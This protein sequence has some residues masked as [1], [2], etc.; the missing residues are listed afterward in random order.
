MQNP[1][2]TMPQTFFSPGSLHFQ[3]NLSGAAAAEGPPLILSAPADRHP[4][5]AP[6]VF[7]FSEPI[8]VVGG[9][10]L[11][12]GPD[13][14]LF[15][16]N[17]TGNP[18]VKVDGATLSF[19]LPMRLAYATNYRIEISAD[20]IRDLDGNAVRPGSSLSFSFQS[21]LSPVA[22]H[23]SGNSSDEIVNGSDLADTVDAAG[24]EDSVYG[25]GGNDT[26]RGG[27]EVAEV[28]ST[29][30]RLYGGAGDDLVEGNDG[31]DYLEG[32]DGD[33]RLYGGSG[34]DHLRGGNGNDLVDGG[35]GNDTLYADRGDN[36]LLGGEGDDVLKS[37][38]QATGSMD[39]GAGN[40]RMEGFAGV[41]YKGGD[42]DDAIEVDLYA[43]DLS[44]AAATTISGGGGMDRIELQF[45]LQSKA[46][47]S[48][49]AGSDSFVLK[50][51][52]SGARDTA[53]VLSDFVAGAEGEQ[54]D[55]RELWIMR[56]GGNPF[57][58]GRLRLLAAGG[59]TLLQMRETA[60][61]PYV[62]LLRLTGVA[63][64][65]LTSANFTGGYDPRGSTTGLSL[66]GTNGNDT[67][68]G[69]SLDDTILGLAGNDRIEGGAGNDTIEGG[70]GNDTLFGD[71]GNNILRG[72]D[73]KD[74]LYA[75]HPGTNLLEGG[76][77]DDYLRGGEGADT[78]RG[79]DGND[80][81]F[82][83]GYGTA[84]PRTVT[85]DG[86]AGNDLLR[87]NMIM[88]EVNINL[89]GG[90]GA[91]V[92]AISATNLKLAITDFSADD[93]LDLKGVLPLALSGNAF[94]ASGY[95][96][97]VQDGADTR[98]EVDRDGAA[99]SVHG[100]APV[101]LLRNVAAATLGSAHFVGGYDPSGASGGVR[102]TGTAGND[103]LDGDAL[104]D[105]IDGGDGADR[106]QGRAG[107]DV[108][109]GGDES[110]AG[111]GD[112]ISGGL[113]KD[114]I[115]GGAG[116]DQLR[117]D[118]DDDQLYGDAG[119]DRLEG[120]DGKDLLDG[121]DGDDV[122]SDDS[123]A[124]VMRGGAGN[125]QLSNP[126]HNGYANG[127]GSLLDGGDGDDTIGA[128][129]AAVSRVVG[130][131]G[132]DRIEVY[133][134]SLRQGASMDIDAGS[135]DDR[136]I[137][138]GQNL[139]NQVLLVR[140]R[141]GAGS[142]THGTT[143]EATGF[144]LVVEDFQTGAGGDLVEIYPML[145]DRPQDNPFGA[146][147]ARLVQDGS[148]VLL[149]IDT[150][151]AANGESFATRIAF[152]N[153][154]VSAFTS[155]NFVGGLQPDGSATGQTLTGGPGKD[156]LT[157][158]PL[159]DLL[160]GGGGADILIGNEGKDQL[161]GEGDA[162]ILDGGNGDDQ[163]DGGAGA[164]ELRGGAGNDLLRGGDGDDLLRDESGD[165]Q[166][167]GG[168][169]RDQLYV[170]SGGSVSLFGEGGNDILDATAG[171]GLLDGGSGDDRI[172][173]NSGYGRD[174]ARYQV[175]GG[176][177]NDLVQLM[178][179]SVGS[180][181]NVIAAGGAGVDTY[182]LESRLPGGILTI[183]DFAAGAGGDLLNVSA[184]VSGPAGNPFAPGASLRLEQRGADTVLRVRSADGGSFDDA[185][186][187]KD[188]TLPQL[189]AANF[190]HHFNPD[191]SSTG[192]IA[193]GGA[194][195][196]RMAGG[197][198]ND[199]LDGG[200][201]NDT[202]IGAMGDDLLQGGD[203]DDLLNGDLIDIV[204]G[205]PW[206][207]PWNGDRTGHDRLEGGAG[208]DTLVSTWG[209]DVLLG[210]TGDDSLA[211]SGHPY[212]VQGRGQLAQLD[213]GEGND[214]L[215]VGIGPQTA[216]AVKLT[217]G[218]GSDTF[219]LTGQPDG[220]STVT[221]EDFR[222]GA[223][224]DV[225]DVFG[226]IRYHQASPFSAGYIRVEQRGAD[227]VVQF[228][229]DAK[230][231]FHGFSDLVTLKNVAI[232]QLTPDNMRYGYL[233]D[234]VLKPGVERRAGDGGERIA[235]T[236][237]NDLLVGGAGRD[238]LSGGA[239]NDQLLGGAGL[240]TAIF[241]GRR[242]DY[243][244]QQIT[245]GTMVAHL[246]GGVHDGVDRVDEV[247]RLRFADG[248]LALDTEGVAGQAYRIYRAAFDRSPDEG[249]LGFWIAAMDG[250]ASL[251]TVAAGFA[252]SR[253]FRDLYGS[254]PANEEIVM[255]LYQNILHR[256]PEQAGY[257]YWLERLTKGETDLTGL[258]VAFSESVENQNGTAQLIANGIAYQPYGG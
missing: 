107:N 19:T 131:N 70:D 116:N 220:S 203:G 252:G 68:R 34:N 3:G 232:S 151:G 148:R 215:S 192:L 101:L 136:V 76:A 84:G 119:V 36:I 98:V 240:D 40:D 250:G 176:A 236:A 81:L 91:D 24:G 169:G 49:G 79:G 53:V 75:T 248:N 112:T 256:A 246:R 150:D 38:S 202:L 205:E 217:G 224:G 33:D 122:L 165:D 247:E 147:Y 137:F 211:V 60:Q 129:A 230:E 109:N 166:M 198:L 212:P 251:A 163:L 50:A 15:S 46:T 140:A 90:A 123:G 238:L 25:W 99:G 23:Y 228:D 210:G 97:L 87:V 143:S 180:T 9:T 159:D 225:L 20:A 161:Y 221:I 93:K 177:G 59:D 105:I 78:L 174:S 44:E 42:G 13:G 168:D 157:G 156:M 111:A 115:R 127:A 207:L 118:E 175:S 162:D 197:W 10:L 258:L 132:N 62:T 64:E 2:L 86:G 213:G 7:T 26:L 167:W 31:N 171:S 179:G 106:I 16:E 145:S 189:T 200:A 85:L 186:V 82:A 114:T 255:R 152:E 254:A 249:G 43:V 183:T 182:L 21:G 188:T 144:S 244:L 206:L 100:F 41:D 209:D 121:G 201:G 102:L 253:E 108:L 135:G 160:R 130:G 199:R 146:G 223:G 185:I 241:D 54:I 71:Q 218:A 18:K 83:D 126:G 8:Q 66:T 196:E 193:T 214:R 27:D 208:N 242:A 110:L 73:G 133:I 245:F 195:G 153:T 120:G 235:G 170:R 155:A 103:I 94:G 55:V 32:E 190:V 149:Q 124:N 181:L 17:L 65:Q 4:A 5:D 80:E 29:G 51:P 243:V 237:D 117:G 139:L 191:G 61:S 45:Y 204:A 194:A 57:T 95:L 58:D 89:S 239:G 92:F 52:T 141:G 6:F 28:G 257:D 219:V 164:D 125:D 226:I 77:G 178:Q 216:A 134:G 234:T 48:G 56:A 128:G 154:V 1:L 227:T 138:V 35:A 142:D 12:R 39:G 67:L 229:R 222:T 231:A 173:V 88:G 113:G 74:T 72:G 184:L 37:D 233:P 63:P 104:D 96:R 22:L 14:I 172:R 30:D 47:V 158:G 69:G 187:L 11:V